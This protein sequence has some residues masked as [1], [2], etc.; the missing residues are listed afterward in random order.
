LYICKKE[1]QSNQEFSSNKLN[2]QLR[3]VHLI[4]AKQHQTTN[5]FVTQLFC[6]SKSNVYN[7]KKNKIGEEHLLAEDEKRTS[8]IIILAIQ[9]AL[10]RKE[11]F[12]F[13]K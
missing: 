1:F 10:I 9:I 13:I 3:L 12:S 7:I 11:K 2:I 4:I 8:F 5:I 6:E